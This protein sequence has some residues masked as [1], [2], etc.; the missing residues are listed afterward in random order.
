[1]YLALAVLLGCELVTAD[2][3]L[4]KGLANTSW[5]SFLRWIEDV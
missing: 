4:L 3:R 1:V 2:Q 5:T